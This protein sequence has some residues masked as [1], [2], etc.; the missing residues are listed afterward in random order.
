MRKWRNSPKLSAMTTLPGRIVVAV[1]VVSQ[2]IGANGGAIGINF[3]RSANPLRG[4]DWHWHRHW[5][6]GIG[7]SEFQVHSSKFQVK[8]IARHCQSIAQSCRH[9]NSASEKC[10]R[11]RRCPSPRWRGWRQQRQMIKFSNFVVRNAVFAHR[12]MTIHG[13]N[14]REIR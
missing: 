11:C 2:P 6:N 14:R 10:R 13:A 9:D 7:I 8:A 3:S 4:K 1:V 5:H 12:M